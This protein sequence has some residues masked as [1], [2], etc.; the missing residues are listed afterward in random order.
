MSHAPHPQMQAILATMRAAPLPPFETMPIAAARALFEETH[1]RMNVPLPECSARD[2]VLGGVGCQ[3][4][5]EAAGPGLIVFVHGGG[6]TFGSPASH[7]RCA[8]LLA[9]DAAMPVLLPDYRLAPEHPCPAAIEDIRSV[10]AALPPGPLVLAGDSAGANIALAVAQAGARVDMLSLCYGCFAPIFDTRSHQENGDGAFGLT[11]QRM[12]WYWDN[13]LGAAR[14]P[15]GA[16]L[17]GT[18]ENLPRTHLLAAG[19][20]CLR[21][22][23]LILSGKLAAAGVRYRLDVIPGVVHGF[24]QMSALLH[25]ARA[26]IATI[27]DAI[28]KSLNRE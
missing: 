20:D 1:G 2:L 17:D 15:R 13:W 6:W 19:L 21:D 26:A 8:R 24:L 23:T 5:N 9:L 28:R 18:M 11:S 25:P 7:Q 27:A 10:L 4:L 12:R 14:D 16:P 22:D 3:L